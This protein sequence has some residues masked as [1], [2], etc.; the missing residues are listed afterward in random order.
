MSLKILVGSCVRQDPTVLRYYLTSLKA[1]IAP[2]GTE[3]AFGFVND[4]DAAQLEQ[5]ASIEP[6]V[7][8]PAEERPADAAYSI[9]N[10]T[11]HWTV[12]T[13]EHLA[14]QKQRLLAYAIEA[15]YSHVFLVDSD[16]LLEPT[17]LLSLWPNNTVIN[18]AVFWT[19]WQHDSYPQPQCW[20]RHPYGLAGLGMEEHEFVG[21]LAER[22]VIRCLGGGACTL[23]PV[24][25]LRAGVRYHPRL[26]NLPQ[27]GMWQ[28][29]DRTFA[30]LAS[31]LHVRQLADGWPDIYHA[32]HPDQRSED[33]LQAAWEVLAA[34]RQEQAKYGDMVSITVDPMEDPNLTAAL[35]R[36]SEVRCWRGRLG[37]S[38]LA[39]EIE[40]KLLEM[41]P[42]EE[43]L[44]PI[45][46]PAWSSV[47]NY[48]GQRKII[49][50]R[51][52]DCKPF[53]YAPVLAD[54]AFAG[55]SV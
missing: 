50:L 48:R 44:L 32:Y 33:A 51:L 24:A 21:G 28:G 55:V 23:V 2:P 15:G 27:E 5:L 6:A 7:V 12:P 42:G 8:L 45:Q 34:P 22:D 17:T 49:R 40:S 4:G 18:N 3:L 13:F 41:K 14:R 25:A 29:E 46:H 53:S 52:L 31:R 47:A 11:H 38:Q 10:Q 35:A 39:P 20:L 9:G 43:C 1:L 16:L 54:E 36:N 26:P 37:S 19:R 30:V